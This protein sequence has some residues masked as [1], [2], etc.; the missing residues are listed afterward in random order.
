MMFLLTE[1]LL[2]VKWKGLYVYL[3]N[4]FS[5]SPQNTG[6][7][8]KGWRAGLERMLEIFYIFF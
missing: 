4:V 8:S 5:F 2:E 7:N 3:G 6:A 1:Q